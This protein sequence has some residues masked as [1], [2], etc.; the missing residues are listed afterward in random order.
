MK[1]QIFQFTI[2]LAVSFLLADPSFAQEKETKPAAQS[3]VEKTEKKE[4]APSISGK[5][6]ITSGTR[7]G[8]AISEERL[9]AIEINEKEIVI[10][11]GP[12]KF[13]M[14]YKLDTSKTPFTIDMKIEKGPVPDGAANGIVKLDGNKM[15][16]CY[17]GMGGERPTKFETTEG[18][19]C[20]YFE[21]EME[22]PK[23]TQ[24][25]LIGTWTISGGKRGG[26]KSA[27]ENIATDIVIS[28]KEIKIGEGEEGFTMSY[29]LNLEKSPAEIDMKITAGPA[30]VGSPATGIIKLDDKGKLHLCYDGMGGTRP[31]KFESTAENG[32][33]LF[34]M[35]KKK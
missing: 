13:V 21:L 33:F 18:D 4:K 2:V 29:E 7:S 1:L 23:L 14:S 20:F 10:P 12:D 9:T 15:K 17:N 34:E 30:P 28:K 22:A 5:W 8:A 6:N 16:L 24:E 11:A 31:E 32:C 35:E 25:S 19:N 27:E 26:A 3:A